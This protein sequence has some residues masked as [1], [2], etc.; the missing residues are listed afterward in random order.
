[1]KKILLLTA[2][3]F[4][5]AL[6]SAMVMKMYYPDGSTQRFNISDVDKVSYQG[7]ASSR[8]IVVEY[9][10]QAD[11]LPAVAD[12]VVFL[13]DEIH[14]ANGH[15]YVDLGLSYLWATNNIGAT[16][17]SLGGHYAWAETDPVTDFSF[18]FEDPFRGSGVPDSFNVL[19]GKGFYLDRL[20]KYSY[21]GG[22]CVYDIFS[23]R[24][25]RQDGLMDLLPS[26]DAAYVKWGPMWSN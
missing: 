2:T 16:D 1:M 17:S 25:N 11:T 4:T 9:A 13:N 7:S 15:E 3:A 23:S 19:S 20:N 5:A 18:R 12:S 22:G 24:Y 6:S 14:T 10:S 21:Y 26:D 8:K